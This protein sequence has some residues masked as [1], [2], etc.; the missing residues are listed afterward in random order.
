MPALYGNT[1]FG[2]LI[3]NPPTP[4]TL[5]QSCQ[6]G[7]DEGEAFGLA[8]EG[9]LYCLRIDEGVEILSADSDYSVSVDKQTKA[10]DVME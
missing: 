7:S 8:G 6:V 3:L 10:W 5:W 4:S 2:F 1:V 9:Q